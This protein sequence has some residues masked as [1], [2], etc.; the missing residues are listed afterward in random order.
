MFLFCSERN[1]DS[2]SLM[3]MPIATLG[4]LQLDLIHVTLVALLLIS[5]VLAFRAMS[6]AKRQRAQAD[7]AR[8]MMEEFKQL[9]EAHDALDREHAALLARFEAL[10]SGMDRERADFTARL[11]AADERVRTL[12][13]RLDDTSKSLEAARVREEERK[14][15]FDSERKQLVELRAEVETKFNEIAQSA[16]SKSQKLF[17]ETANETFG[18]QKEAA[19]GNLK[20][21]FS[22]LKEAIGKFETRVE[23][24]EKVRAEDKSKLSEQVENITR[25]LSQTQTVTS[26]LVNALSTPRGG[27]SWGEES[28]RNALEL[29]GVSEHCDFLEQTQDSGSGLRPDVVLKMPGGR[30]IVIDSKAVMDNY[31]RASEE[32]DDTQRRQYLM[33]HARHFKDQIKRLA[34]KDYWKDIENRVDF[35]AMWVP[36]ENFYSAALSVDRDLFDFAARNRVLIV[37]PATLIALAK[38][39]AYG[40]RQE[41]ASKNA[42]EAAKIGR[43][44]HKRLK[45]L[46]DHVE[47]VG[48]HLGQSV[49][50]YNR[51]TGSY[52]RMVM[53]QARKFEELHLNESGTTLPD[54]QLLEEF[55]V[56]ATPASNDDNDE[57]S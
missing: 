46:A 17:L 57:T 43:E 53:S 38:A 5:L 8:E 4:Q 18:R 1:P 12:Q 22:P 6:E 20:E 37:T 15:A 30:E 13:A 27:G 36:G 47:K 23:T 41:E 54:I 44:L 49:N 19:A 52:D 29:A 25:L 42:L 24:I 28:L 26:K 35:V 7:R 39:V 51:M 48:R 11:E 2:V 31:L 21:M 9:D 3:N 16:L 14:A 45:T 55:P 50:A 34:S 10:G 56:N 32:T 33:A 40:W